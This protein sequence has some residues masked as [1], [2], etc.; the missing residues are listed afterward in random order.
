MYEKKTKIVL[1]VKSNSVYIEETA[2]IIRMT[3]HVYV[4]LFLDVIQGLKS[5]N[6]INIQT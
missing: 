5:R 3:F 2:D 1:L 6:K 4:Q